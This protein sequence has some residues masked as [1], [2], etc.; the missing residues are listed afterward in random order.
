MDRQKLTNVDIAVFALYKLG[1]AY[2]KIHTEY[3]AW[4]SYHLSPDRFSWDLP[5][6]KVKGFPD[7]DL[8]R[9]TLTNAAKTENGSLVSGRYG[10]S[11]SN[12]E[13]DGWTLTPNGV[14][15]IKINEARIA[16]S[17]DKPSSS[18]HPRYVTR[19]ISKLKKDEA[20][21]TYAKSGL[22]K[23]TSYMFT[24]ML[25]CTPDASTEIINR[26]YVRL[27]STAK[28]ICD[29][30]VINFLIQCGDRFSELLR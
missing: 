5:E 1:G 12:K 28:S 17:L 19:F 2:K 14:D 4:E 30:E 23:V 24:D 10:I 25:G 15:W 16:G 20:Y 29:E 9:V 18:E 11:T 7:K 22:E 21:I 26:K 3:V 13:S 8:V 27:L 6:F